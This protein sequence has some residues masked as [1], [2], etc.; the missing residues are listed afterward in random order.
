MPDQRPSIILVH[1]VGAG[2]AGQFLESF[3][4]N[5]SNLTN[6]SASIKA[7]PDIANRWKHI[8]EVYWGDAT[9]YRT[10]SIWRYVPPLPLFGFVLRFLLALAQVSSNGWSYSKSAASQPSLPATALK[11]FLFSVGIPS[12]IA[13]T[14]PLHFVLVPGDTKWAL[15]ALAALP[16]LLICFYL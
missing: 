11:Y 1:G 5:M 9:G 2:R 3:L 10:T 12:A 6:R 7:S 14:L 13:F 16:V 8:V 15:M 4:I